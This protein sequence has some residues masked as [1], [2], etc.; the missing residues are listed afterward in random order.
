MRVIHTADWHLG[1]RLVGHDRIEEHRRFLKWLLQTI[2]QEEVSLL[3]VAGDIFDSA[4]PPQATM[5]MYYD[6][7]KDL[8]AIERCGAVLIAGNHDSPA[9]LN[10]PKQLLKRFQIHV[11]GNPS[12][13]RQDDV[14]QITPGF[15]LL[16][17]VCVCAVP[18]LRDR[19]VQRV[20]VGETSVLR[21]ERLRDGIYHYYQDI[22]KHAQIA[23]ERGIPLIATGH[24][25][26]HASTIEPRAEEEIHIGTLAALDESKLPQDFDYVALGHLH[27][28][29]AVGKR[30]WMRYAG[31]P[32]PMS[33]SEGDHE[34][35][36]VLLDFEEGQLQAT[37]LLPSPVSRQLH[38]FGGTL[39][40]LGRWL[41]DL[42]NP[43]E[44]ALTPWLE[45]HLSE[46]ETDRALTDHVM[47]LTA[48]YR[49][50]V[51]KVLSASPTAT[52]TVW[53]EA[54]ADLHAYQPL[55]V[56]K[57]RCRAAGLDPDDEEG[58]VYIDTFAELLAAHETR[59]LEL[60]D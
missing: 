1:Q 58:A 18:Y 40:D 9:H 15:D 52:P 41:K 32:F 54:G 17:S 11:I 16:D 2:R 47:S 35:S 39:S 28:P 46:L 4:H 20:I 19:D 44:S 24:L 33:F 23:R 21:E 51:L 3:I 25:T 6:F 45:V 31:S 7:L 5:Q 57:E 36:V 49:I 12:M 27:E 34:K 10:A 60:A 26:M 53:K 29:H 56:F 38:R 8:S 43:S 30:A 14:I 22:R 55:D 37:H 48:A 13:D 42:D 59:A 50:E